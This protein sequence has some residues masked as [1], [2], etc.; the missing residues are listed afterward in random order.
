MVQFRFLGIPVRILP[1]FWLFLLFFTDILFKLSMQSVI[2]GLVMFVSL[3]IHEYGH[4][5]TAR[6]FGAKSE[7][8]L[9]AFGGYASYKGVKLSSTKEFLITLNGPLL[10]SSLIAISYFLLKTGTFY[11]HPYIKYALIV[12]M[13]LNIIWCLFNL[14]PLMP[15]DGGHL[16]RYILGKYF[17][18]KGLKISTILGLI[19]AALI[20]PYLFYL[21]YYWFGILLVI[22]GYQNYQQLQSSDYSPKVNGYSGFSNR[23]LSIPITSEASFNLRKEL[24][25]KDPNIK[26]KAIELLAKKYNEEGQFQKAYKILLKADYT[27]LKETK[28]LLCSLAFKENNFELIKKYSQD[29]YKTNPTFETAVLNS[30]AYAALNDPYF[31]AGWLKTAS[32]FGNNYKEKVKELFQDAIYNQVKN[33]S[34]FQDIIQEIL[35][36]NKTFITD[37]AK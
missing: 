9:E 35:N 2:I 25:S 16:A 36:D 7:I 5:V 20:A 18:I 30:K 12:T 21:G 24:K 3:L 26:I 15:L 17:G 13:R 27:L 10:E 8:T 34:D 23:A 6:L 28:Y 32:L 33:H 29:V 31:A 1:A 14:I 22:F 11:G 19:C 4:A 37:L